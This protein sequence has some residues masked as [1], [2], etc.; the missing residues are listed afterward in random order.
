M[1]TLEQPIRR[2]SPKVVA[3]D[4][5]T[6]KVV[7]RIDISDVMTPDSKIH[8]LLVDYDQDGNNYM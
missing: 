1:N 2:C 6:N 7:K 3:I 4:T 5:K 8:H